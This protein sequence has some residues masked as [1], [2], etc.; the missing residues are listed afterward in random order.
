MANLNLNK[1]EDITICKVPFT[2][3]EDFLDPNGFVTRAKYLYYIRDKNGRNRKYEPW[4]VQQVTDRIIREERQRSIDTHGYASVTLMYLKS[5][6]EGLSTDTSLR[7]VDKMLFNQNYYAQMLGHDQE[8]T[9]LIYGI[10]EWAFERLPHFVQVVDE[11]S[12]PVN[13]GG[14]AWMIPIKPEGGPIRKGI[15]FKN[16]TNSEVRIQTA[17]KGDNAGKAGSL[18]AVHFCL[19]EDARIILAD[20]SSKTIKE[21]EIDDQVI[22]SDGTIAPVKN[23]FNTGVK[24]T[25]KIETWLSDEPVSM[26]KDHKVL[27]QD[28]W[29][30]AE[31]LSK[32]D[33]I[34]LPEINFSDK[35]K[36]YH[37]DLADYRDVRWTTSQRATKYTF[38]I[39]YDFGYLLGYYLA[40]GHVKLDR[41]GRPSKVTFSHHDDENYISR[42]WKK[43]GFMATSVTID[44]RKGKKTTVTKFN[45]TFF[46]SAIESICGRNREKHLPEW[47][48]ETNREFAKGIV[49]GYLSGD[50][51]KGNYEYSHIAA[52]SVDER[53]SRQMKRLIIGM[54]VGV[55]S[56]KYYD[57]RYRYEKKTRPIYHL[58]LS[59]QVSDYFSKLINGCEA[60][61][62]T[63]KRDWVNK[64][65]R[66]DGKWFVKI[67][68]ISEGKRVQTYDIEVDHHTHDFETTIGIVSNSEAANYEEYSKVVSSVSQQLDV[69]IQ[70]ISQQELEMIDQ[71][72]VKESTANGT[73]GTGEGFYK[74]WIA[75]EKAWM[76]YKSGENHTFE[77]W[78]PVFIPWYWLYHMPL[79]DG[80]KYP[81]DNIDWK[82]EKEKQEYIEWEE[83][84]ENHIIPKDPEIDENER[85]PREYTNF[86]RWV[87]PKKCD[88]KL[89]DARRYYPTTPEEAFTT[90]DDCWFNTNLLITVNTNLKTSDDGLGDYKVGYLN[91]HNDFVESTGGPLHIKRFPDPQ[92]L[93]RYVISCDQSK[94]YEEG[95]YSNMS[96]FDRLER[97]FIAYWN[98][99]ISENELAKEF[100][101]M[102]YFYNN[103]LLVPEENRA[104]VINLIKPDGHE[105]YH[106][107]LYYDKASMTSRS[108]KEPR[109]GYNQNTASRKTMLDFY[110]DYL[111]GE[112]DF[113]HDE[114]LK[115]YV[116][117]FTEEM[118]SEHIS[119]IRN[120][121]ANTTKYEAAPGH[122]DDIVIGN[123]LCI[124]GDMWWDKAPKLVSGKRRKRRAD[125]VGTRSGIQTI[126]SPR[127]Q[128]ELG[129]SNG[130]P[131]N[132]RTGRRR[133]STLGK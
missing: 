132:V 99:I 68:S 48:F 78:R 7:I 84:V 35:K 118:V 65:L 117:L 116:T 106:G 103:G 36:D 5:R 53:I 74:D 37:F 126:S 127:R 110:K 39:D 108:R 77:G 63:G 22:T 56:I 72:G 130:R 19:A 28:G 31:E 64:Y 128:S 75:N 47:V 96:V 101:K 85:D 54:G 13:I 66:K 12:N 109:W 23:K 8:G 6:R 129:S 114:E 100:C 113:A 42:I 44:D 18:N 79:I 82:S 120:P 112:E 43:F 4:L 119:F 73:S 125:P 51:S 90:S 50:G 10:Y 88:R 9:E 104:T 102:G 81:L 30:R 41:Q 122:K 107:E 80:Q 11:D 87:I 111:N 29:K 52:V 92:W 46:A 40:E 14:S 67:K 34:Q 69:D 70:G 17:G 49:V 89:T 2:E 93:Y 94:G 83:K 15:D 45:G 61:G 62:Y 123:A 20:G 115:N 97:D 58:G 33:M 95:D 24:D 76:R 91:S 26:S 38:D 71:F 25:L 105:R 57:N 21:I 60:N 27:T 32:E 55:P 59:G 124:I 121:K 3:I 1:G 86:Y 131:Y 98:A 16:L 133:Q